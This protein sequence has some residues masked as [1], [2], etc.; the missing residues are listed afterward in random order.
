MRDSEEA[1]DLPSGECQIAL[2]PVQIL[3]ALGPDLRRCVHIGSG[4]RR[5]CGHPARM[6]RKTLP[7]VVGERSG[8]WITRLLLIIDV[9]RVIDSISSMAEQGTI[10][11]TV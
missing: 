11:L 3:G 5:P 1:A 4:V 9:R 6:G 7:V 10:R 2:Q 8:A